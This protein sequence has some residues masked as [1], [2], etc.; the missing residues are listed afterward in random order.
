MKSEKATFTGAGGDT[1]AAKLESPAGEIELA[2]PLDREQRINC[3][4]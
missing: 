3:W 2:G 4:K 1:L